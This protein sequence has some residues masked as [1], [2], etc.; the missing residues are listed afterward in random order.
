M[1]VIIII[2]GKIKSQVIVLWVQL[3]QVE[4]S[5]KIEQKL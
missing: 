3:I 1:G 2:Q 4:D 5:W